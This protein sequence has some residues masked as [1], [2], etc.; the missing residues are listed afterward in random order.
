MYQ[1][2]LLPTIYFTCAA[3]AQAMAW[4]LAGKEWTEQPFKP[5]HSAMGHLLGRFMGK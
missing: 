5:K 2:A 3:R 1:A 4:R